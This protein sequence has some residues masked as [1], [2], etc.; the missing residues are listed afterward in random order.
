VKA[1]WRDLVEAQWQEL[2]QKGLL[3]KRKGMAKD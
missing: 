2:K 3:S 1:Q